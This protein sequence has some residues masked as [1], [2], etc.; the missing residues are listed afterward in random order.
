MKKI[1]IYTIALVIAIVIV[2]PSGYYMWLSNQPKDI[3]ETAIEAGSF[4]TLVTALE[5]ADLVDT[6]KGEGP[7]TVFAPTDDAF[8]ALPEGVLDSLLANKTAL[9]EVLT[10]HVVLGK[11]M[12]ADVVTL[13]SLTT[14]QG[15][16][17]TVDTTDGVEIDGANIVQTDIEC[18]NGVIH[19]IDSVMMPK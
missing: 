4:T 2:A 15:G 12:A 1:S 19:V 13:G 17:L 8:A 3:V 11:F 18:T 14:M 5:A 16:I 10:Y 7:F 6:L 9:I